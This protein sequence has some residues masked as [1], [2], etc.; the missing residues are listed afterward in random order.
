MVVGVGV[1]GVVVILVAAVAAAVAAAAV[2]APALVSQLTSMLRNTE[3]M[4]TVKSS[5]RP[6]R[7]TR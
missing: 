3:A 1:A 4:E 2:A 7:L 5:T 6:L